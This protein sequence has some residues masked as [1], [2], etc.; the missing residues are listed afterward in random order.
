MQN[1]LSEKEAK[2]LYI[3][4]WKIFI[5]SKTRERRNKMRPIRKQRV[6]NS[7]QIEITD[8]VKKT[9]NENCEDE[10]KL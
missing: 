2:D 1:N 3:R 10:K 7:S 8:G 5:D 9:Q 4:L 6:L